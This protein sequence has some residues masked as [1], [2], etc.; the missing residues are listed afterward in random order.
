MRRRLVAGNRSFG[1]AYRS[2]LETR[3]DRQAVR[4][5]TVIPTANLRR[6]QGLKTRIIETLMITGHFLK[7]MIKNVTVKKN[8]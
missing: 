6:G 2:H 8:E 3:W 7:E 4:K 5:R 1:T